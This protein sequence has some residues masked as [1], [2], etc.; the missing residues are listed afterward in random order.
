MP[1]PPFFTRVR[2]CETCTNMALLRYLRPVD[3]VLDPNVP[4][5]EIVPSQVIP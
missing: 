4:L 5:S 2:E 3:D 1:H